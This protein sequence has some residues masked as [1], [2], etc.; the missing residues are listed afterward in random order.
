MPKTKKRNRSGKPLKVTKKGPV[1]AKRLRRKRKAPP[2]S[3]SRVI[4]ISPEARGKGPPIRDVVVSDVQSGPCSKCASR[5][6]GNK[7]V[8]W[9]YWCRGAWRKAVRFLCDKH[10]RSLGSQLR[11]ARPQGVA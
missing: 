3:W 2:T 1:K 10:A 4:R 8:S 11:R 5:R 9:L 6:P 7:A